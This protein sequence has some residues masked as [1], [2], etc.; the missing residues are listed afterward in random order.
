[1]GDRPPIDGGWPYSGLGSAGRR[2]SFAP[3]SRVYQASRALITSDRFEPVAF[4]LRSV[5]SQRSSGTRMAR[6]GVL[7]ALG[8]GTPYR[9]YRHPVQ[10]PACGVYT[11]DAT[12]S[13]HSERGSDPMTTTITTPKTCKCLRCGRTLTD[14]KSVARGYGPTCHGKIT[15]AAKVVDAKPAQVAKAVELIEVGGIVP[16]RGR[17]IFTVVASNGTDTYKTS[18]AGCTCAAGLRGKYGCYHRLAAELIAARPAPT[19]RTIA[20]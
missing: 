20:A 17:R 2:G 5:A 12:V 10:I 14:P 8:T 11:P 18:P 1:M 3:A 13:I 7:G 4:A 9:V 19:R 16:L 6:W 15:T